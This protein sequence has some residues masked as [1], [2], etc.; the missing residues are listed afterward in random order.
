MFVFYSKY[1][2]IYYRLRDIAAY[3]WKIAN[4]PPLVFGAPVRGEAVRFTQQ[5][6]IAKN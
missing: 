6:L 4:P 2:S 5:P 1:A 3:W